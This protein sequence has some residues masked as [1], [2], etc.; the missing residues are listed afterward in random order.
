[1][2]FLCLRCL[3]DWR[4]GVR[5]VYELTPNGVASPFTQLDKLRLDAPALQRLNEMT[6]GGDDIPAPWSCFGEA[7]AVPSQG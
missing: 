1:M 3:G 6:G 2:S 7:G 4:F 5:Y